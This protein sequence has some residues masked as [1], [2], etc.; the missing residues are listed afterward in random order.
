MGNPGPSSNSENTSQKMFIR[1]D[2]ISEIVND[3][4]SWWYSQKRT[5]S[6]VLGIN[7]NFHVTKDSCLL[8][9]LEIFCST[10]LLEHVQNE[11]N[12]YATQQIKKKKQDGL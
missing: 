2:R 4:E 3:S 10:E 8:N 1:T 9:V 12:R 7:K 11:T 6:G 5:F